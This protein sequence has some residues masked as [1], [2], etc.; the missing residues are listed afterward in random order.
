M[1]TP[2]FTRAR[3]IGYKLGWPAGAEAAVTRERLARLREALLAG[4][5]KGRR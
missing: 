4:G 3:E 5:L 2:G 1:Q